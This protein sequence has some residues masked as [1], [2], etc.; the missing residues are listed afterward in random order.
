MVIYNNFV[1]FFSRSL[2]D[3]ENNMRPGRIFSLSYTA[4][5]TKKGYLL[6]FT[7]THDLMLR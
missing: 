6:F 2:R 1:I 3:K 5:A 4:I 7:E